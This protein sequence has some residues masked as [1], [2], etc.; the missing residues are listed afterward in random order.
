[1]LN[2]VVTTAAATEEHIAAQ[3][4]QQ[5]VRFFE[6]RVRP[7]TGSGHARYGA[8]GE[9]LQF[10]VSFAPE[11]GLI[12]FDDIVVRDDMRRMGLVPFM[13]CYAESLP[14]VKTVGIKGLTSLSARKFLRDRQYD[15]RGEAAYIRHLGQHRPY[16][17]L[18]D[19]P[20]MLRPLLKQFCRE[21]GSRPR[22]R[23]ALNHAA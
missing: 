2:D 19:L 11:S 14:E 9:P 7:M 4:K 1:M 12:S 6:E 16:I 20:R 21:H 22:S 10:E 15:K 18:D 3:E 17:L 5:M 23:R 13:V 8:E